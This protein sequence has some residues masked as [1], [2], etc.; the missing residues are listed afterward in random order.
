MVEKL[1]HVEPNDRAP[2]QSRYDSVLGVMQY[3]GV[4]P[5]APLAPAREPCMQAVRVRRIEE[6]NQAR[7]T[8]RLRLQGQSASK[9]LIQIRR[10]AHR[11]PAPRLL[12]SGT[13]LAEPR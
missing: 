13:E 10:F 5:T 11:D 3:G 1:R 7:Q 4:G 12:R 2:R 6:F 9:G 8:P